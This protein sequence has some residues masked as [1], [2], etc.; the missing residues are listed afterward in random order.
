MKNLG[1]LCWGAGLAA[2]LALSPGPALSDSLRDALSTAYRYNPRLDAARATLRATDEEVARANAG[3]RP[4]ITGSGDVGF[5]NVR[6]TPG[7]ATN[8]GETHPRGYSVT[9]SQPLFRGFR[10][11]NQVREA[12]ATVRAGRETLR[13]KIGRAHV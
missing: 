10:T 12:E 3:Y 1:Q 13:I 11:I 7:T 4:T 8:S 9:A 5:Q 6:T 2:L